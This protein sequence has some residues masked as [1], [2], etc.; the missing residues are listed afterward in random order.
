MGIS[1]PSGGP[2]LSPELVSCVPKSLHG[3]VFQRSRQTVSAGTLDANPGV[4]AEHGA[5]LRSSTW[6]GATMMKVLRLAVLTPLTLAVFAAPPDAAAQT[7]LE[8]TPFVG[9]TFFL[10]DPPSTFAIERSTGQPLQVKDGQFSDAITLGLSA[11][12]RFG[13]RFGVDGMFSWVPTALDATSLKNSVDAT[14]LM[15]ALS[16]LYYLPLGREVEPY[17]GL[18]VGGETFSYEIDE[19]KGH[20]DVMGNVLGGLL[21]PLTDQVSMRLEARDCITWFKSDVSGVDDA[22]Q[23]D[24]MLTFGLKFSL[25]LRD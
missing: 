11:G 5:P 18:G 12:I 14:S 2:E 9:G 10:A 19:W 3:K 16:V 4:V 24:L 25:G 21:V 1:V 15:Y 8:L 7:A 22:A 6:R 20:T 17:V 13:E 23:N